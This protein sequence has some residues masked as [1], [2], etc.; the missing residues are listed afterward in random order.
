[1]M[2]DPSGEEKDLP[3]TGDLIFRRDGTPL[4]VLGT[5]KAEDPWI[6]RMLEGCLVVMT[7][8]G[9]P[10]LHVPGASPSRPPITAR[11]EDGWIA[12]P[13]PSRDPRRDGEQENQIPI[14][15]DHI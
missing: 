2:D 13:D 14:P 6:L 15:G 10:T 9:V 7:P 4:V 12:I 1:M 8:E 5:P 11:W 3:R